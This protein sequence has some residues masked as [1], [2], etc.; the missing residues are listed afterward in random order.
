M[1]GGTGTTC[2]EDIEVQVGAPEARWRNHRP[3]AEA[4][5]DQAPRAART[6]RSR[7]PR[8]PLRAPLARGARSLRFCAA[9]AALQRQSRAARAPLGRRSP[10]ASVAYHPK[11]RAPGSGSRPP[12]D[13][14]MRR[15]GDGPHRRD[16]S[17]V[18][19]DETGDLVKERPELC[20]VVHVMDQASS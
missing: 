12:G 6:C 10:E 7:C 5:Q 3:L 14:N 16:W 1:E 11:G 15:T 17:Q 18:C 8:A 20:D 2:S 13:P 4:V 19:A 9:R